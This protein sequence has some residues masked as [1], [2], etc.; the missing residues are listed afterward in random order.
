MKIRYEFVTGTV[1]VEVSAEMA[2]L[3][4]ELDRIEYNNNHKESNQLTI[5]KQN[6]HKRK[7]NVTKQIFSV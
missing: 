5:C 4:M 2:A 3:H 6:N 1:E 7:K